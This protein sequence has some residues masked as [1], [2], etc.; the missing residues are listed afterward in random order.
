[1]PFAVA[2]SGLNLICNVP[3]LPLLLQV[4][5][6]VAELFVVATEAV[7]EMPLSFPTIV[8]PPTV[9]AVIPE[10]ICPWVNEGDAGPVQLIPKPIVA[11]LA[12]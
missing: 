7:V 2:V 10:I 12:L 6:K 8:V 5:R 4:P 1:M 3:A 11:A 9:A